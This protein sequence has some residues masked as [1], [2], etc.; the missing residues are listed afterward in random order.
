M[1]GERFGV[2][3][4]AV[5]AKQIVMAPFL[6][7]L[8]AVFLMSLGA[9]DQL[10]M[11]RMSAQSGEAGS[12]LFIGIVVS[13]ITAAVMAYGGS[14]MASLLPARAQYMLTA[15]AL[16]AA[17][18]ELAWRVKLKK[19]DEPTQSKG[20][21]AIVLAATQM[22]DAARFIV[23]AFAAGAAAAPAAGLGGAL[24]GAAA[25]YLGWTL[26]GELEKWPLKPIRWV[27]AALALAAGIYMALLA[28]GWV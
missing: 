14:W 25:L 8:A 9:R 18:F 16:G 12:L 20:A 22:H 3:R 24:G 23:F 26:G 15:F 13:A 21:F 28:R 5:Q 6:F 10:M 17:A 4:S 19:P 1:L 7:A 2:H 11:A 27:L